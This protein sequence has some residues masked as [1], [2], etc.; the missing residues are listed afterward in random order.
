MVLLEGDLTYTRLYFSKTYYHVRKYGCE[1]VTH[2]ESIPVKDYVGKEVIL[3]IN[4]GYLN[5]KTFYTDSM[6]L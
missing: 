5:S 4:T 1:I 2:L 6:G 3:N